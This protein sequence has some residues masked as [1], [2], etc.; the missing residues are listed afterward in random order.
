MKPSH[1]IRMFSSQYIANEEQERRAILWRWIMASAASFL[2]LGGYFVYQARSFIDRP[3]L[4]LEM[5]RDGETVENPVCFEG[6]ATPYLELTVNGVRIYS[7]EKGNFS[8]TF[9]L[10]SGLHTLDIV[11]KDRFEKE[12]KITRHIFVQ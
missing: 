1:E 9:L 3:E 12:V 10:A 2:F 4:F 5:P 7:D 8:E 6:R 11:G